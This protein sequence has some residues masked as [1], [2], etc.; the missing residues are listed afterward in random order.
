MNR[1]NVITVLALSLVLS[2]SSTASADSIE[3][4]E[5]ST[6]DVQA[7]I[8]FDT[9]ISAT[10]TWGDMFFSYGDTS[11]T[12]TADGTNSVEVQNTSA[13]TAIDATYSYSAGDKGEATIG[14]FT[15]RQRAWTVGGSGNPA[16][17]AD[18][19]GSTTYTPTGSIA[20]G[21]TQTLYLLFTTA[22]N[23][24]GLTENY[25]SVGTLQVSI[26]AATS[27]TGTGDTVDD[28]GD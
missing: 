7:K 12:W 26:N 2:L 27:D 24:D 23:I 13:R 3:G 9:S 10:V 28:S 18:I 21:D 5:S 20:V 6:K 17:A 19:G 15:S 11:A 16:K 14:V 8:E 25:S 1:R 4:N 22:D